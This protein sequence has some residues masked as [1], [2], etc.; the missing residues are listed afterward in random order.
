MN[1][2]KL[3]LLG[4]QPTIELE[5]GLKRAYKDFLIQQNADSK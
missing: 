4:W 3:N 5:E 1:S 2:S